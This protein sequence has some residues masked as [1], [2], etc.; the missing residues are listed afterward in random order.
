MEIPIVSRRRA[1]SFHH[2]LSRGFNNDCASDGMEDDGDDDD[3][4]D[5]KSV[6]VFLV[7]FIFRADDSNK[8]IG[9][10][11]FVSSCSG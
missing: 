10:L 5:S 9:I 7:R 6:E 3:D 1:I 8:I 11:F 4:D 2:F